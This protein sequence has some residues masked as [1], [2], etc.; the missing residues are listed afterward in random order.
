MEAAVSFRGKGSREWR[1]GCEVREGQ[2]REDKESKRERE[3]GRYSPG[4]KNGAKGTGASTHFHHLYTR[5]GYRRW[6]RLS[7]RY[8]GFPYS[9]V[10]ALFHQSSPFLARTACLLPLAKR[11]D[12][13]SPLYF[14]TGLNH[15]RGFPAV[16]AADEKGSGLYLAQRTLPPL[17][18][19]FRSA[20]PAIP[21]ILLW[22]YDD[23]DVRARLRNW[24]WEA[25]SLTTLGHSVINPSHS[26]ASLY[27]QRREEGC[28]SHVHS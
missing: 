13:L 28:H 18:R 11:L 8:F 15:R 3:R 7:R 19:L 24:S 4:G 23:G 22:N 5:R 12:G 9:G 17:P 16:F 20:L 14:R 10:S 25:T 21:L 1:S 6:R 27:S 2:E 26:P